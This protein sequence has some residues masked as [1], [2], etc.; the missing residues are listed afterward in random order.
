MPNIPSPHEALRMELDAMVMKRWEELEIPSPL[1]ATE[2]VA[3]DLLSQL[4]A[5]QAETVALR[6]R[7]EDLGGV[8]QAFGDAATDTFEQM[9]KGNWRD[10][11]G[12]PVKNNTAM[13]ALKDAVVKAMELRA[14]LKGGQP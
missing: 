9:L 6:A 12:H 5:S 10:D 11:H 14:A 4:K 2:S 8:V 7:V 1:P 3:L 13:L